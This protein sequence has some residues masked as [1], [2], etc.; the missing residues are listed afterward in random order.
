MTTVTRTPVPTTGRACLTD[1]SP[2]GLAS[3]LPPQQL[4]TFYYS[5]ADTE[6]DTPL[7]R[8][9]TIPYYTTPG[10]RHHPPSTPQP[11]TTHTN[12]LARSRA[13]A[14]ARDQLRRT[15]FSERCARLSG[16]QLSRRA[17]HPLP[18]LTYLDIE[19]RDSKHPTTPTITTTP[20]KEK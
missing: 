15:I 8:S 19:R 4:G 14:A 3:R 1:L 6:S 13:G 2:T 9:A 16:V 5:Q 7:A 12:T 17:E 11:T 20:A 18:D 10:I